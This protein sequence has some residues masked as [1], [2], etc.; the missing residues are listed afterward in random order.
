VG[1]LT[2]AVDVTPFTPAEAIAP[3]EEL[4]ADSTTTEAIPRPRLPRASALTLMLSGAV[5]L[6]ILFSG[7]YILSRPCVLSSV[8][9]PLQEAEQLGQTAVQTLQTTSDSRDVVK[10]HEQLI[11]ANEL[12]VT[13]PAWS[14]QHQQA[15]ALLAENRDKTK[16][17][18]S[19]VEA[20]KQ[21][22]VASLKSQN[23]PLPVHEWREIQQIW[24][25]SI[26]SLEKVPFDNF[27]YA[28]AERKLKEYRA[29]LNMINQRVI[30]ENEAQA[31]LD[32]A[33]RAAESAEAREGIAISSDPWAVVYAKWQAAV[34]ELGKVPERSMARIEAQRLL[35]T[36]QNKLKEVDRRRAQEI[37]GADA[38]EQAIAL[39]ERAQALEQENQWTEAVSY[40]EAALVS[41]QKI[42]PGTA[43]SDQAQ[44]L[45]T[46]YTAALDRAEAGQRLSSSIEL[47]KPD[48]DR[49]CGG[50]PRICTYTLG[51]SVIRVQITAEYDRAVEQTVNSAQLR[52]DETARAEMTS[53]V[54]AFLQELAGISEIAQVPIE[55]YNSGGTKFGTYTPNARSNAPSFVPR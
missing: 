35:P 44:Q 18:G 6:F 48:L 53:Q 13:I 37:V 43:Y 40:W 8:C 22:N 45:I 20:L 28:L 16:V 7:W 33:K 51:P 24:R 9:Q 4:A 31:Q 42:A 12:L 30:A 54:N 32:K 3:E 19:V 38:Y 15:Q 50:A 36:Y 14:G 47:A 29:N 49:A 26:A 23:P 2:S 17:L 46:S 1:Q 41:A 52:G 5:G 11:A 21:A 27:L 39:A 34:D 10:A 55:L 25:E